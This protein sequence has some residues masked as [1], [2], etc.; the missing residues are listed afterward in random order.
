MFLNT[1]VIDVNK[2]FYVVCFQNII[3][4]KTHE[5]VENH[6]QHTDRHITLYNYKTTDSLYKSLVITINV[7]T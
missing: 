6:I 2:S 4:R 3:A 5:T 1:P 7:I